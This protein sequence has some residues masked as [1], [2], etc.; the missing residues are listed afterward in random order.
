MSQ[1]VN[2]HTHYNY[3]LNNQFNMPAHIRLLSVQHD[4]PTI[5]TPIRHYEYKINP[6]KTLIHY[7]R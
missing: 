6:T 2:F 3:C 4:I 5:Q 7:H 1:R